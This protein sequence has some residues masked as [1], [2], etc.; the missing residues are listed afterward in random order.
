MTVQGSAIA[1]PHQPAWSIR[2]LL[3][4][5]IFILIG[6]GYAMML[7]SPLRLT[8]DAAEYLTLADHRLDAAIPVPPEADRLPR[9]YPI[10]LAALIRL[11]GT[12]SAAFV[13]LN[14]FMLLLA[15]LAWDFIWRRAL[16][17]SIVAARICSILVLISWICIKHTAFP[18]SDITFLGLSSLSLALCVLA[19]DQ[20]GARRWSALFLGAIACTAAISVRSIGVALLPPLA[21]AIF[22][23]ARGGNLQQPSL[24][25]AHALLA[26]LVLGLGIWAAARSQYVRQALAMYSE[27]GVTRTLVQCLSD[28]AYELGQLFM[29]VPIAALPANLHRLVPAAGVALLIFLAISL[30]RR[31]QLCRPVELYLLCGAGLLLIWP[32]ADPRFWLPFIPAIIGVFATTAASLKAPLIKAGRTLLICGYCAAGLGALFYNVRLSRLA[33]EEFARR[34][35]SSVRVRATYLYAFTSDPVS[36]PQDVDPLLLATLRRHEPRAVNAHHPIP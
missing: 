8:G 23:P 17:L 4:L 13:G 20:R 27:Q 25:P 3:L 36:S 7:A 33:P 1:A 26:L 16:A 2:P 9:G 12:S 28:R 18:L 15:L 29:N 10:L 5:A 32:W 34:F 22:F 24:R 19:P 6:S 14:L 30:Y 11:G 21:L 31:K 35:G